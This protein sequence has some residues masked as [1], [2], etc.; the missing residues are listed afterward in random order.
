MFFPSGRFPKGK[1]TQQTP[2]RTDSLTAADPRL[3][4]P[5][6]YI[7]SK[8]EYAH[9]MAKGA[10][11]QYLKGAYEKDG[12]RLFSRACSGRT[13]G[14]GFTLKEGRFRPDIRKKDFMMRVLKPWHR[15]PREV[16]DA[17][18]LETFQVRLDSALSNLV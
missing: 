7:S 18:S 6:V 8:I 17:P 5:F 14:N 4:F 9:G 12:E 13:K 1:L 2:S 11:F 15:L 16:G 10:A 3:C